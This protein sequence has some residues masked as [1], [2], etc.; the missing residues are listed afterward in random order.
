MRLPSYF[1][2]SAILHALIFALPFSLIDENGGQTIPITLL[3]AEGNVSQRPAL[4]GKGINPK[5]TGKPLVNAPHRSALA[6][7]LGSSKVKARKS[8]KRLSAK[9]DATNRVKLSSTK[10][11]AVQKAP[12]KHNLIGA[13]VKLDSDVT[14]HLK[15]STGKTEIPQK[16]KTQ[17][18]E[19]SIQ[20]VSL[21]EEPEWDIAET[22]RETRQA[23]GVTEL[24]LDRLSKTEALDAEGR[25]SEVVEIV[26]NSRRFADGARRKIGNSTEGQKNGIFTR[27]DY[28]YRVDPDYPVQARR[29]GWEGTTMLRV[30]VDQG[31]SSKTI[32]VS[33]S[34]G[35]EALDQAATKAVKGWRFHPARQGAK[36]VESWVKI[37]IIFSLKDKKKVMN[38]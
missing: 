7:S 35:F 6:S 32:Q 31:G 13:S 34:S 18:E 1:F 8:K 9:P 38:R 19:D 22:W 37:P 15:G 21:L 5:L 20:A 27:A 10:K 23:A 16:T 14:N 25:N 26:T 11:K 30:L 24:N 33:Q 12:R 2:V 28:A 29:K 3:I 36:P 17:E 4:Q